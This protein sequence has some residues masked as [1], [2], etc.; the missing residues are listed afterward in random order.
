M[1]VFEIFLIAVSLFVF[2][3]LQKSDRN[4]VKKAIFTL[5]GVLLFEFFVQFL[6]D[7]KNLNKWTFIYF[8]VNWVLALVWTSIILGGMAFVDYTI[9]YLAEKKKIFLYI[10]FVAMLASIFEILLINSGIKTYPTGAQSIFSDK[11]LLNNVPIE[12]FFYITFFMSLVIA[13]K[14]YW[15]INFLIPQTFPRGIVPS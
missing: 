6:F 10:L 8:D 4:T 12:I 7:A 11:K 5:I 1:A 13:F 15:E 9:P 14:R 2:I 3:L